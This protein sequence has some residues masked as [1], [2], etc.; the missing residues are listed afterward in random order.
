M[1]GVEAATAILSNVPLA[2]LLIFANRAS[3][4]DVYGQCAPASSDIC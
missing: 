1:D 3:E 4:E 2:Q